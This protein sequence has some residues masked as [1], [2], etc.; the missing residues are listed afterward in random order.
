MPIKSLY[1]GIF[2]YSHELI[3]VYAYAFNREQAKLLMI[4]QLARQHEVSPSIVWQKF[5]DG[6]DN[7]EVRTEI[8]WQEI[9]DENKKAGEPAPARSAIYP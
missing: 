5:P 7:H 1:C 6:A 8:E 2:N 9:D 3:K 4:K